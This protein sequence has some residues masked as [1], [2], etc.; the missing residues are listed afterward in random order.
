M[1]P[2][3]DRKLYVGL[4]DQQGAGLVSEVFKVELKDP[5]AGSIQRVNQLKTSG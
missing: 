5:E 4:Q 2:G 3:T 1:T